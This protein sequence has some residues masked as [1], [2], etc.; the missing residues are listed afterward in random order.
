[1][2]DT[3]TPST[4][5]FLYLIVF[6]GGM[7]TLAVEVSASRLLGPA[8]GT[9]NIIWANIIGLILL[10]LTIGYFIGGR[11]ADRYPRP[12]IMYRIILWGAFLSAVIPLVARPVVAEAGRAVANIDAALVLGSFLAILILFSIPVTLLGMISPFA[13]RLA[14]TTVETSGKVTGQIYAIST[15]GS[16]VGAFLPTLLLIPELGVI[17]TFLLF[18]G[19]LYLVALIGLWR[20]EG[21]KSLR[22]LWM[23][24][25]IIVLT[26]LVLSGPVRPPLDDQTLLFEQDSGYNYIQV[27]EDAKGNRYLYLNEGQ[28]IH[29]QWHPTNYYYR[30][31]WDFFLAAPYFNA[32]F[33]PDEMESLLVIGL[34]TGTIARQHIHVYGDI[35]MEGIEIDPAIIAAGEQFFDMNA[36]KMPSLTAIAGDGRYVLNQSDKRY[37]VIGIDAYK[38]PYIPWHLTTV[39]F[40]QEVRAHLT[41]NGVTVINVGRTSTD[42]RFV[43][44]ITNT[45]Q[46]VFPVVH[47]LD[48]PYSFNTILF[49]TKQPSDVRNLAANLAALPE[50]A[51]PMLREILVESQA[52]L[53][54][55]QTIDIVFTDNRAPV[56]TLVDSLIINFLLGGGAEEL[57]Q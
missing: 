46:Q 33:S 32:N 1:L 38:P 14:F 48:V 39:E 18:A 52:A 12:A 41:E 25:I 15:L 13:I 49:A 20:E 31:T 54:P 36:E 42:R 2:A 11:L 5:R 3:I 55:T 6:C 26:L 47:S 16:L 45:M 23:P 9:G 10:Y 29:S 27:Q 4:N 53:V 8:F 22:W 34:A 35:P 40:F 24:V 17:Q 44:A 7:T 43:E 50:T 28:G 57:K 19:I 37:T 51:H 30:R 21:V 56:E